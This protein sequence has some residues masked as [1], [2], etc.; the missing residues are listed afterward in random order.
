[1]I[2]R[3]NWIM[4][5]CATEGCTEPKFLMH[6]PCEGSEDEIRNGK[7]FCVACESKAFEAKCL[8]DP[9]RSYRVKEAILDLGDGTDDTFVVEPASKGTMREHAAILKKAEKLRAEKEN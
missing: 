6:W 8:A 7:H 5:Q 4:V 9:V 2:G 1:M 3:D